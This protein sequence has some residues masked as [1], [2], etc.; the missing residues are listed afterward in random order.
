MKCLMICPA[1]RAALAKLAERAPLAIVPILGQSLVEYWL[2]H[3]ASLGAKEVQVLAADRP[4]E[5]RSQI[6]AGA[7]W[8]LRV[9]VVPEVSELSVCE[10][11]AKYREHAGGEWLPEPKDIILLDHLPGLAQHGLLNSYGEWFAAVL[12]W[13]S[14]VAS[15]LRIGIHQIRPGVWAGSR[16]R[17]APTAKLYPPCWLGQ[18]V[19][20]GPQA[21]IGPM[22]V[23]EDRAFI[24]SG[25]T[26]AHSVVGT[27]TFVGALTDLKDSLAWGSTLVNWRSGISL[28][29]ADPL[30]LCPLHPPRS[31]LKRPNWVAR[32]SALWLMLATFPAAACVMGRSIRR[33]RPAFRQKSAVCPRLGAPPNL[34][35]KL[36]YYELASVSRWLRRWPQLWNVVQG[37]FTWVG[38]RPLSAQDAAALRNASE[39]LWLAAPIG[40]ISLG[41][42]CGCPQAF[43]DEARA[44]ASFYAV[45]AN[46]RL[47][48]AIFGRA[49]AAS[50][51]R[52]PVQS[53]EELPMAFPPQ[54]VKGQ[55]K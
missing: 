19:W 4:E 27:E 29:S 53:T 13:F 35:Q 41:D 46:W 3:L 36:V 42:A 21:V 25:A 43:S 48:C 39:R 38:N 20:V 37:E 30:L 22:A 10:A 33:G 18:N 44:H 28:E 51:F 11:R 15:P 26:V 54:A 8:G 7:R 23:V 31:K 47:D 17:I 49:L 24:E 16:T 12:A 14:Q 2:E 6:G 34:D 5:M 40:L 1:E 52:T 9:E 45:K 55:L 50:L 32:L